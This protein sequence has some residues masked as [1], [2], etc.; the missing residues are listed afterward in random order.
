MDGSV[1]IPAEAYRIE[2]R[3]VVVSGER[4]IPSVV[5]PAFGIDRILYTVLEHSY[6]ERQV[7]GGDNKGESGEDDGDEIDCKN[8]PIW[9]L[10]K[11]AVEKADP[12]IDFSQFGKLP[13]FLANSWEAKSASV[14][15][16]P[17]TF[18]ATAI[19]SSLPGFIARISSLVV[20]PFP[21]F[22]YSRTGKPSFLT[23][24]L[25]LTGVWRLYHRRRG[26][27]RELH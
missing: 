21:G 22:Y 18:S 9:E 4:F 19:S 6:Y 8:V 20:I 7:E 13:L 1:E 23:P 2:E 25:W 26:L 27:L 16:K 17:M 24:T 12:Q 10:A 3:E 15:M 14:W 11:E 5:E